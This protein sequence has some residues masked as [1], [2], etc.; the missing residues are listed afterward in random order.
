[1]NNQPMKQWGILMVLA[2]ASLA[3]AVDKPNIVF[4]FIDDMG[5]G[6]I[7][8]FGSRLNKTPHLD[9]MAREG[10]TFT[11]FY[12]SATACTPSRSALMTGCYADRLGMDG[13]VV[14]P[15]DDSGRK[16]TP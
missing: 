13:N 14:F 2:T 8:P 15:V 4:I 11:D 12:V 3:T 5:Y 6:D 1:M 9:R 16:V 7:D 10:I